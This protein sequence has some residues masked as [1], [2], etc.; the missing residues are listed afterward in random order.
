MSNKL[1]TSSPSPLAIAHTKKTLALQKNLFHDP[2]LTGDTIK[3]IFPDNQKLVVEKECAEKFDFFRGA[4]DFDS[5]KPNKRIIKLPK[6]VPA[7]LTKQNVELIIRQDR[8]SIPKE[9]IVE[10]FNAADFLGAKEKLFYPIAEAYVTKFH[11]SGYGPEYQEIKRFLGVKHFY[12][13]NK[14]LET[15]SWG[16]NKELPSHNITD[17]SVNKILKTFPNLS[18]LDLRSNN[19]DTL[20]IDDLANLPEHFTLK[21]Q[22]NP[23]TSIQKKSSSKYP[24]FCTIYLSKCSNKKLNLQLESIA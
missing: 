14:K 4:L 10:V 6:N 11:K 8:D 19:I 18:Y 16:N 2:E 1:I 20:K 13:C 22:N 3:I 23:I 21:L 9:A 7:C 15:E 5:N 12:A 24:Q 17:F